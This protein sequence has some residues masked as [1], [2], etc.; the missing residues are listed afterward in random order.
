MYCNSALKQSM[1]VLLF[2]VAKRPFAVVHI[3]PHKAASTYIE[4]VLADKAHD[5]QKQGVYWPSFATNAK[6][7]SA[8]AASLEHGDGTKTDALKS[9]TTF[10]EDSLRLQRNIIIA[11][12]TFGTQSAK[13]VR[14]LHS[15]LTGFEVR[16]VYVYRETL[17]HMISLYF[18]LNR[19][20]NKEKTYVKSFSEFMLSEMDEGLSVILQPR[21][22]VRKYA[23]VFGNESID[24]AGCE[25][26]GIDLAYVVYCGIA[27]V[28]CGVKVDAADYSSNSGF[29]LIA[30]EVFSHYRALVETQN[31]YQC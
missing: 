21:V 31:N 11:S 2:Q 19:Y 10:F 12:E 17:A 22:T 23:R 18:Q 25:S 1:I 30:T 5:L 27:G 4:S 6:S 8:F 29:S 7:V 14:Y 9:M 3:G 28:L 15:L 13:A 26:A 24:M 20:D 16:I